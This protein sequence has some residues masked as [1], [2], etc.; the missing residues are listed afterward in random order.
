MMKNIFI[1]LLLAVISTSL[2]AQGSAISK[3][4]TFI[5][6][7]LEQQ[8]KQQNS[9]KSSVSSILTRYPEQVEV[10]VNVALEL[11]PNEYR[12]IMSGALAAEPVLSCYVVHLFT[13]ADVAPLDEIVRLAIKEE[14]AYIQEIMQ[15][16]T[17]AS[18]NNTSNHEISHSSG[19]KSLMAKTMTTYPQNKIDILKGS[20]AAFPEQVVNFVK[21]ALLLFPSDN[22]QIISTAVSESNEEF[23]QPIIETA[24]ALG[25]N[26]ESVYD[27]AEA[28]IEQKEK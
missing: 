19:T 1:L 9:I 13:Q 10:V 6:Q 28:G 23:T 26:K 11:Y 4:E 15:T 5:T 18:F 17:L 12:Q 7:L 2:F 3:Q 14:P 16:A 22:Y 24:M 21:E 25:V 8:V 20:I 27:A